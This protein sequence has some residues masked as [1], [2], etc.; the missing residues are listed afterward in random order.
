ML[1]LQD[2]EE[3]DRLSGDS[4]RRYLRSASW[5]DRSPTANS[6]P[7][8]SNLRAARNLLPP[9]S[10][11]RRNADE[12]PNPGSDDLGETPRG[13]RES[14]Q[15]EFRRDK[16]AFFDRECS[17]ISDHLFLGSDLVA[18][19]RDALARNRITHVLNCVGFVCPEYF[20]PELTYKTLWLRDTP[21]ED[22]TS[23]LYDVFDYFEEVRERKGRVFV[24]C[25]R[26][27]SR[28]SSLVIAYLMWREGLGFDEA[29]RRVR[30]EREV[31]NPNF[32]FACQLLQV[33]ITSAIASF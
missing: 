17:R 24:H 16:L 3:K 14:G 12:W 21:S 9:L 20:K 4:R 30:A 31:T 32:G 5:T 26:G 7:C 22:I 11:S 33:K 27:V 19:D 13:E 18:R 8:S 29:F 10:I 25:C 2:E 15:L 1:R 6:N 28:S 23:V